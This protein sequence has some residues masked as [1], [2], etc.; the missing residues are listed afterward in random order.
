MLTEQIKL[1]LGDVFIAAASV[2]Y[3]G[4]F[5]GVYR[6]ELVKKWVEKCDEEGI[7][8]TEDYSLE[9]VLGDPLAIRNWNARGLPS[10]SVSVNNGI[11]VHK[12]RNYPLMIDPQLQASKWLK[13]LLSDTNMIC[14]KMSD[15]K[16]F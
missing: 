15:E 7:T 10:D 2:T 9:N 16:L 14:M 1:L 12:C 8:H 5:T 6:E 13:Q 3:Y 11:L 4:P